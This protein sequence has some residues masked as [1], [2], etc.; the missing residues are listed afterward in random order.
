MMEGRVFVCLLIMMRRA[1]ERSGGVIGLGYVMN[2]DCRRPQDGSD[3]GQGPKDSSSR[4]GN[5]C[6]GWG[7]NVIIQ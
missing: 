6:N 7:A 2:N 5:E 1:A 3:R 4:K